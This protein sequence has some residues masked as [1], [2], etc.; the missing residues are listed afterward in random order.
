LKVSHDIVQ[1]AENANAG[2]GIVDLDERIIYA[3]ETMARMMGYKKE[4]ILGHSMSEFTLQENFDS[5][6]AKTTERKKGFIDQYETVLIHKNREK[7]IFSISASPLFSPSNELIGTVGVMIDITEKKSALKKVIETS[8]QMQAIL[9]AMPD[10]IFIMS[11]DGY[12]LNSFINKNLYP[13]TEFQPKNG[14]HISEVFGKAEE[15]RI[16]RAINEALE[17]KETVV[18]TFSFNVEYFCFAS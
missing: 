18:V 9:A 8:E 7:R 17:R 3:N 13:N 12:Y 14:Q 5:F 11:K 6:I 10:M 2:I 16:Q 4:E 1:F 15:L